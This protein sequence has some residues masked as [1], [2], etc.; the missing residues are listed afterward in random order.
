MET[1]RVKSPGRQSSLAAPDQ[2]TKDACRLINLTS[3]GRR[4]PA[5][6]W[7]ALAP[8]LPAWWRSSWASAQVRRVHRQGIRHRAAA[9][10]WYSLLVGLL[11]PDGV[12]R[13]AG[14]GSSSVTGMVAG[15]VELPWG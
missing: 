12:R 3:D 5:Q 2:Q 8:W 10:A 7:P 14:N 1:R 9:M 4:T 13:P 11:R 6:P 15:F